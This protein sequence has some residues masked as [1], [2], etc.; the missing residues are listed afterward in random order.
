M[1]FPIIDDDSSGG[2]LEGYQS[3][4]GQTLYARASQAFNSNIEQKLEHW[5]DESLSPDANDPTKQGRLI[6]KE[7]A[8]DAQKKLGISFEVPQEGIHQRLFDLI[9]E[10]KYGEKKRGEVIAGGPGG[11]V[12][13]VLGFGADLVG[14][15]MDPIML[16]SMVIPFGGAGAEAALARA[17]ESVLARA[18]TRAVIGAKTGVMAAASF[19]P[20]NYLLSKRDGEDYDLTNSMWNIGIGGMFGAGL[21]TVFPAISEATYGL[22]DEEKLD[23]LGHKMITNYTPEARYDMMRTAVAQGL[24]DRPIDVEAP[25]AYHE[26][27]GIEQIKDLNKR[28]AEAVQNRNP[29]EAEILGEQR[30]NVARSI[31]IEGPQEEIKGNPLDHVPQDIVDNPKEIAQQKLTDSAKVKPESSLV[32]PQLE[33]KHI[34]EAEELKPASDDPVKSAEDQRDFAMELAQDIAKGTGQEEALKAAM[35]PIDEV[36]KKN[37]DWEKIAKQMAIC[38]SRGEK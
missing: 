22:S 15:S 18:G 10:R 33:S 35:E 38:A 4:L 34:N 25:R 27:E 9:S 26:A 1:G 21:H 8:E 6:P 31:N 11:V 3:T 12:P 32:D 24:E 2:P 36:E 5:W 30:K 14:S 29:Y 19:E 7:E 13:G 28:I 20:A 23:V 37:S 17:G 16:S